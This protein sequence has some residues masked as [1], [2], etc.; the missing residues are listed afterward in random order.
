MP[1]TLGR[2]QASTVRKQLKLH[3]ISIC[4]TPAA[5]DHLTQISSL[6]TDLGC[7]NNEV[8]KKH[9]FNQVM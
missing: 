8:T 4:K 1:P 5:L 6:L 7:S 3:L 9:L 2:S